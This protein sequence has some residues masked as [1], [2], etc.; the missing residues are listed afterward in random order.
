MQVAT[1]P[2]LCR[3]CE[4]VQQIVES[5]EKLKN[6]STTKDRKYHQGNPRL[7]FLGDTSCPWWLTEFL[8]ITTGNAEVQ[9]RLD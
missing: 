1:H 9:L 4:D 6:Q 5:G 2:A 3:Y 8:K 7:V